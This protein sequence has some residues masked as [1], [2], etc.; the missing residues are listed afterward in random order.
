M[1]RK[2]KLD[3][4]PL[5][6]DSDDLIFCDVDET[7]VFWKTDQD[8]A[9]VVIQAVDP[10]MGGKYVDLVPHQ[11]NI[12]LLKRNKGQGRT[13]VV[14]SMGG[15][16]WAASVIEALGLK[17]YVDII[18]GKPKAYIDDKEIGDWGC[19]RVYLS[20]EFPP[21]YNPKNDKKE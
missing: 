11:R 17:D 4:V 10:Y 15:V 8:P 6:L 20:K 13:I 5:I 21:H 12:D 14:W 9:D 18:M 1:L 16:E 19:S 3:K 7:L 2:S